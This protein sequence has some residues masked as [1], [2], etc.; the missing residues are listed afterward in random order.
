MLSA[1][2]VVM[3][4]TL[5]TSHQTVDVVVGHAGSGTTTALDAYREAAERSGLQIIGTAPSARA[6]KELQNG[7]GIASITA[8]RLTGSLR[9]GEVELTNRSVVVIDEAAMLGTKPLAT[10]VD[11]AARA[12]AKVVCVGDPKQLPEVDAGGL[13][14]ALARRTSPI[15]LTENRR[16]RDPAEQ[17]ALRDLRAGRVDSAIGRLERN[18]NLTVAANS[19]HLRRTLVDDWYA[20][21]NEGKHA[22]MAAPTR[23]DVA[24][25]NQLARQRLTA[26][27]ALGEP[28][29]TTETTEYAVGDRVLGLRNRYDLGILNG[30][31]G[32]VT[33][34]TTNRELRVKLDSGLDI[35]LPMSFLDEGH[36]AHGYATTVHKAQGMTCDV[37]FL[38]G[39]DGLFAEL[40]YTGLTR[41]REANRLYTVRGTWDHGR[42][43]EETDELAH[44]KRALSTS[45]AQT[46]ASDLLHSIDSVAPKSKGMRV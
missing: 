18:G 22:L 9:S 6:A 42:G 43:G 12:G 1:E 38:L 33:G 31:T 26:D 10:I 5:S 15:W 34:A 24:Q 23:S 8:A 14:S 32:T 16:Q 2:Q 4:R 46:A 17:Q 21:R 11:Y 36:L 28:V 20:A 29:L 40:G 45:H 7:A 37:A 41:G 25:L 44:I 27:G 39:D 19:E 13:F 3:V 35:D 30:D